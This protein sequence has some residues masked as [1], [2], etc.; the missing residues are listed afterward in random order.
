MADD[1]RLAELL[2]EFAHT[3]VG[4]Y[5]IQAILDRLVE[6]VLTIVPVTGA[7]VLLMQADGDLHF[8]AASDRIVQQVE[9]LQVE[10]GEGPCIEAWRTG[11]QVLIADLGS[12]ERFPRFSPRAR[13]AGLGAVFAFPMGA[14]G[15][16]PGA[17]DVYLKEP[18]EI[19]P[20]DV[21]ATQVLADVAASY[22]FNSRAHETARE[23]AEE[24]RRR[25]LHDDLTGLPNRALLHDRL[26]HAMEKARRSGAVA[27]VLFV[28]LDGF[29]SIND[30]HG[31]HAGDLALVAVAD[32]LR[33]AVRPADTLARLSGDEFVIVCEEILDPAVAEGV[34]ERV[35]N[36]LALPVHIE[37]VGNVEVSASVGIAFAGKGR[38]LPEAILRD[39]DTAM[40]AAKRD[41]GSR[42]AIADHKLR[43]HG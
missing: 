42:Y 5:S 4:D 12:D 26:D 28:D 16:R 2:I 7:G 43:A 13:E 11:K 22:V 3:L 36:V 40:F 24:L 31:H 27:A 6:R 15:D 33:H 17:L 9:P 29:K 30:Q 18:G 39:A 34:A 14:E 32:R 35:A 8:A 19:A 41:G 20:E 10:L 38:E 25:A 37:D 1:R 23:T 21:A